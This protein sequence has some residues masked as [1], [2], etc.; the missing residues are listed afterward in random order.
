V[1]RIEIGETGTSVCRL[2]TRQGQ[3][4]A[5]SGV[6]DARP[7][8]FEADLWELSAR[9]PVGV[10]RIDDAEVWITPKLPIDRLLF[11][12][13]YAADPRGWRADTVALDVVAGLVP[14]VAQALW[15]QADRATRLGLLQ[16]YRE[17]DET[18]MVLRG[19]LREADQVR[20]HFAAP[21]PMEIRHDEFTVDVAENR[22]LLASI[23]RMLTVPR[24][25][26]ESRTR[27]RALRARLAAVTSLVRGAQPP[28]WRPNRL[29]QRYHTAL[30]L[31]EIVWRATSPEH[32]PGTLVANG[33]LFDLPRIFEDFVTVAV[34]E[35][36]RARCGG[37]CYP[38]FACHLDEARAVPMRP[39]L[40][41]Q[42]AGAPAAVL[43]AKYKQDQPNADLYQ[44]LAYCTTL[45]LSRGHLIYAAGS[46]APVRHAVRRGGIQI[47]CHA[48]DLE[49]TPTDLLAQ[50]DRL[51]DEI[52]A[53]TS[54]AA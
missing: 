10:A 49:A 4:L 12:V 14:A 7:S 40:V 54:V 48:L 33:F 31:A 1:T 52:V 36:L 43:D 22:I 6:V 44:V 39:D 45:G 50:V 8:A 47:I 38:Q 42:V 51:A 11:L 23:T 3:R 15:R 2:T 17:A 24:V 28:V 26:E 20:R 27:L 35:A 13:G 37:V 29:N 25:D 18:S 41:W 21:L 53:D 5:A 16:G 9:G 19:R 32:I 34:S 30:R 46:A